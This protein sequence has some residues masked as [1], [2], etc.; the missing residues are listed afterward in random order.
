M[1]ILLLPVRAYNVIVS[2]TTLV[3]W[4][5]DDFIRSKSKDKKY[6]IMKL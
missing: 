6:V 1:H 3:Q 2:L 4:Y 5:N